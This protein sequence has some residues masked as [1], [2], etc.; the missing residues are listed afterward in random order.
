MAEPTLKRRG[1]EVVTAR[2]AIFFI[3]INSLPGVR[4]SPDAR[5][6]SI[7]FLQAGSDKK[8]VVR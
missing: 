4:R 3:I 6:S 2:T 5:K 1:G 8:A 7:D